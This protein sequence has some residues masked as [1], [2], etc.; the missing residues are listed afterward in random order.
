MHKLNFIVRRIF[1]YPAWIIAM[2]LLEIASLLIR[3]SAWSIDV[4]LPNEPY[5][6]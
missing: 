6:V 1:A 2:L 4:K 5:G 3:F